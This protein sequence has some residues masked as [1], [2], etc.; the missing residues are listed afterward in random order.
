M[1]LSRPAAPRTSPKLRVYVTINVV[2]RDDEVDRALALVR[3]AAIRGADAF[4]VQDWGLFEAIRRTWPSSSFTSPRRQT[5]TTPAA[6]GGAA[7]AAR[8]A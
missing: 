1:P 5:S 2:V 7:S 4:I 3:S 6:C 8:T